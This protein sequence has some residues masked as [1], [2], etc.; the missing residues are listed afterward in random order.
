MYVCVCFAVTDKEVQRAID[1]GAETREEVTRAC[2]AGG[3]CGSC[4]RRIEKMIEET[5]LVRKP[6]A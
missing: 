4:H 6:A 3:D 1:D 5:R 2:K